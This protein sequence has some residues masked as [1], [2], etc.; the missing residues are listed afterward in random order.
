MNKRFDNSVI[1]PTFNRSEFISETIE[2]LLS[3]ELPFSEIIV[4]DDGS[5]DETHSVLES[6]GKKIR[7][8]NTPNQSCPN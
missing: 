8:I 5:D 4:V 6:Y 2:S 7:V 3:Q 1:I